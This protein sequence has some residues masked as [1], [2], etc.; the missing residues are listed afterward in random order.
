MNNKSR[1]I[2]G[3]H[4]FISSTAASTADVQPLICMPRIQ[5]DPH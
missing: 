5:H 2:E 3:K 1:T 4:D